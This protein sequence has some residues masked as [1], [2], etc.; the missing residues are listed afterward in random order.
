MQITTD[1]AEQHYGEHKEKSF[2]AELVGFITSG[3][4]V[5]MVLEGDNI[6]PIVR[7]MMGATNPV[8]AAPETI[9]GDYAMSINKNIIHGSDSPESAIREIDIFFKEEELYGT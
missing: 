3:P 9:R 8:D 1:L 5:A 6:V 7:A 2:F 4:V